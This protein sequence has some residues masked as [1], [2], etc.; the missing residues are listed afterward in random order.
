MDESQY[1]A[2]KLALTSQLAVI[3]GP[4]GTGKTYV[5][6]HVIKVLLE[7]RKHLQY[8]RNRNY[9]N[10]RYNRHAEYEVTNEPDLEL[11]KILNDKPIVVVTYTNHAL[12]QFLSGILDFESNII[13]IGNRSEDERIREL[14]LRNRRD[15]RRGTLEREER[16][17]L[18]LELSKLTRNLQMTSRQTLDHKSYGYTS[19]RTVHCR[20]RMVCHTGDYI[21]CENTS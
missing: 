17:Y 8:S 18:N 14:S 15:F 1:N 9:R 16:E 4:P 13:R 20:A 12:D 11:A 21:F 7:A 19:K 2:V 3:Q 10:N 5:G 6:T